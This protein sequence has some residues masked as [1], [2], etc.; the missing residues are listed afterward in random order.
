MIEY[1]L[2]IVCEYFRVD[3]KSLR[4]KSRKK[5]ICYPRSIAIYLCRKY[6]AN[7]TLQSIGDSFNRKHPD[8]F[9]NYNKVKWNMETDGALRDD[10][11]FIN[12]KIRE[13][14]NWIKE[15]N[16][17]DKS[18]LEN[19]FWSI[20][21]LFGH[22]TIAGYLTQ[23][24]EFIRVDVPAVDEQEKFTK[25]YGPKA[26]YGITPT[27]EEIATHAAEKLSVRP[28]SL[29]VVPGKALPKP[30][31]YGFDNDLYEDEQHHDE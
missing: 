26:I 19:G 22:S 7:G 3:L 5:D 24:G 31:G 18:D 25:F 4:S 6:A 9:Y 2:K 15:D 10:V 28:V 12:N 30:N 21:E 16:M 27:T 29:W 11:N 23:D 14:M 17:N 20:V 8:I 1:I 13:R